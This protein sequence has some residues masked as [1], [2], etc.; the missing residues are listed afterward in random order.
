MI[1]TA[2]TA[3]KFFFSLVMSLPTSETTPLLRNGGQSPDDRSFVH[4]FLDLVK[5]EGEPSWATSFHWFIFG[6]YLNILT[7]FIPL[8]FVSHNLNWDA[9]YRFTFSFIAIV[10]LAK[11]L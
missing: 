9:A 2:F 3:A 11:V 1:C 4:H 7:I 8:S 5:G 10:P 6:N